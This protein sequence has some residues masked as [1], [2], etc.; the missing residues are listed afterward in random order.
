MFFCAAATSLTAQESYFTGVVVDGETGKPIPGAH[1]LSDLEFGLTGVTN[2]NGEF[3]IPAKMSTAEFQIVSLG[4]EV[5]YVNLV[6]ADSARIELQTKFEKLKE[7][8][9]VSDKSAEKQI[10]SLSQTAVRT[11]RLRRNSS[12]GLGDV[13]SEVDGVTFI[14]TGTNVQLPVI[15]GLYGNRILVLNNGFKHGFQNW[16]SDHAPEIDV[17]GAE[18]VKV[19]KGAA[20]VKYGPDALG[21]AVV[22]ENNG[23]D[24]N[25]DFY[26]GVTSSYQTNGRGYG[27]NARL[28][29]GK[30][31]FSYHLGANFNRIGDRKAPGYNLTNSGMQDYGVQGGMRYA[32][33]KWMFKANYSL[34][35]QNLGILRTS[36]GSSGPALI[37]N[38]EAETPTFIRDFSYDIQEPNQLITHQMAS[39]S[40]SRYFDN[41]D[42][43]TLKYARQWNMRREY[44]VRRNADLPVLDLDLETDD[45]QLEWEHSL[46]D[47]ISGA[48][49]VQYFGQKNRNNPGT[50]VTPFI[51]NYNLTRYSVYLLETLSADY[52]D[53]EL[54]V[55]Y[56]FENNRVGGRDNRRNV[57][58]DGYNFNNVTAS[59]GHIKSLGKKV[60]WRNNIGSG[61][62]PPNPAE[63]FS[64]G[65]HESQT[66]F[67]L[68]RYVPHSVRVIDASSVTL[69]DD[70]D[71]SPEVSYKYTSDFKVTGK[72]NA[73]NA[74]A[75][76]N[77]IQNFIF[78]RPIGVLGTA[79]GPMPTFIIDQADAL[80]AGVDLS[81]SRT[82][83]KN[84][85]V[86]LG[87]SYIW[88]KN[89]ERNEPLINQPP[90]HLHLLV[91]H[92]FENVTVF[93]KVVLEASPS[94]TFRQ[95]QAPRTIPVRDLIEGTADLT[96]DDP[97]FDFQDPPDGYF[98]LN[99]AV[100]AYTGNF[101][102][103][104]E[105]R[106]ALNTSYRNYLNTMRYF[107]DE[108]GVNFIFSV[109]YNI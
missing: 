64:F 18:A 10:K 15:H 36:V 43:I 103:S 26:T 48:W 57:F 62:R 47:R 3:K 93:D 50:N 27:I 66:T 80:F 79:R 30:E 52:G 86:T 2:M 42:K 39:G 98:L 7:V 51:P 45:L 67:G 28:G 11:E 21:G 96:I 75:Y 72:K 17:T 53:W 1:L 87:A 65:Q 81:Y 37:R 61:W 14:S 101:S 85:K 78:S 44:D 84:G 55:R 16:G 77:Y 68:L 49:G 31:N 29:E 56:D 105:C 8:S 76:A 33:K 5:K 109:S 90:I 25:R 58:Q 23:M 20:A 24:F 54:G 94:Y 88:T 107:A 106:N 38:M 92:I 63:L 97:I 69:L 34:V 91:N 40:V 73:L 12:A 32:L 102:F 100:A 41:G 108:V 46:S 71:V 13:L 104:V 83:H 19:V 59:L 6:A 70:S 82:Y 22:I 9:I 89:R 60:V 95:F 35:N 99:A 74:T 4:F